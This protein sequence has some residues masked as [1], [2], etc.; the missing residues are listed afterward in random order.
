MGIDV[1]GPIQPLSH[2]ILDGDRVNDG[3]EECGTVPQP[4]TN[5]PGVHIGGL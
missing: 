1:I 4:I 3:Y 5:L 2:D